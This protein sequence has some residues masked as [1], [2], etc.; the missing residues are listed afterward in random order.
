MS[1]R[2]RVL[3]LIPHLG[4]GGAERVTALL[5]RGLSARK[6]ELHLGLITGLITLTASDLVPA[7]VKIHSLGVRRVRS[8]ALPLMRL[9]RELRPDL[10]LSGMAHLNFLVLLLRPLFPSKTRVVVRQNAMVSADLRSSRLPVYTRYLYR[11]LYPQADRI[12]C[13][14][15]AMAADLVSRSGVRDGQVEVLPNP[16]DAEAMRAVSQP[17]LVPDRLG[18]WQGPGPH[19]LAMGRLSHEKGF[20]LLMQAFSSVRIQYPAADLKILGTGPE[21]SLLR[22][23]CATL[24]LER[25]VR[26]GGYV[27]R[28]ETFFAGATLFVLPSRQEGLPNALLEGAAGGLPIVALPASEGVADLLR[29]K[30]GVWLGAEVSARALTISLMTAL[31]SIGP[32]ERFP[33]PW[34]EAFQME[35]A[36]RSY[37]RLID[38]VLQERAQ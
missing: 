29:G 25:S 32:G 37:E 8:A 6:Y 2:P 20:D 4:G 13:Q 16:V 38:Q 31:E 30:R 10:I 3:L 19:L 27:S 22:E 14:T 28:P 36:I 5:A 18:C 7:G 33:H 17:D 1:Q 15:R 35:S 26:F 21:L 34:L 24:Q 9:V 23:I 12:V 11:L